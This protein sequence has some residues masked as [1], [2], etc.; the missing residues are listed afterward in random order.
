MG[1][2]HELSMKNLAETEFFND[3]IINEDGSYAGSLID[4][5]LTTQFKALQTF[6]FGFLE[7]SSFYGNAQ[8][9]DSLKG[10]LYYGFDAFSYRQAYIPANSMKFLI[11]SQKLTEKTSLFYT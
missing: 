5:D 9:G 3:A 1:H 2:M 7:G 4:A 6:M 8:C 10:I 11:S